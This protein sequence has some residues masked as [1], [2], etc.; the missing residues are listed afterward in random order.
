MPPQTKIHIQQWPPERPTSAR[1]MVSLQRQ[2]VKQRT[3]R[4]EVALVTSLVYDV[5]SKVC[6]IVDAL[7]ATSSLVVL[8]ER[9][10]KEVVVCRR[11]AQARRIARRTHY[12]LCGEKD[13]VPPRD[14]DY[15]NSPTEFATLDLSGRSVILATSN[16]TSAIRQ[17]AGAQ[18]VLIG[19]L[20]NR[21]AVA[22]AALAEAAADDRDVIIVCAGNGYGRYFSLEDTFVAGA[23]V[24]SILAQAKVAEMHPPLWNDA[25]AA[26]RLYR[27]YRGQ[28]LACFRDADHARSLVELGLEHDLE[29]CARTD[30]S[31]AVPRVK[32][33]EDDLLRVIPG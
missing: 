5:E 22:A 21:Q 28:A 25:L 16:G 33:G 12:L 27:S 23:I 31:T 20:L 15:G 11:L 30:V 6:V 29:F 18:V 10:V 24:D 9:G 2:A 1:K 32:L 14:F 17:V 8:I 7:R 4:I 3:M 26:L 19:A 13:S